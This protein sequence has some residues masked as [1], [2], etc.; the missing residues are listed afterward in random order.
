[1]NDH[2]NNLNE[3]EDIIACMDE[4]SGL[5]ADWYIMI[6]EAVNETI[7]RKRRKNAPCEKELEM[8]EALSCMFNKIACSGETLSDWRKELA[9]VKENI[10]MM[11]DQENLLGS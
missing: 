4:Y 2:L 5:L 6:D 3:R 10:R 8:L 7:A 1:M 11:I 9:F